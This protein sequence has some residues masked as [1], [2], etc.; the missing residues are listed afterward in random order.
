MIAGGGGKNGGRFHKQSIATS[1]LLSA[2][3]TPT[4]RR[5]DL[6]RGAVNA[7]AGRRVGK[8]SAAAFI[9]ALAVAILILVDAVQKAQRR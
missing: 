1:R 4:H 5:A 8:A 7:A 9:E 6:L 3:H 2:Y